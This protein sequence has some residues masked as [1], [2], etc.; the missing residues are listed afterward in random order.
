MTAPAQ[1]LELIEIPITEIAR[2]NHSLILADI[3]FLATLK[4]VEAT[5]ASLTITDAQS[6]QCAADLLTRLTSAGSALEKQRVALKA[7][8]LTLMKAIDEAAK[9]PAFRIEAAK[10]TLSTAQTNFAIAQRKLAE[11]AERAR[12]AELDR[13]E[14]LR[15]AEEK[16]AREKAARIAEDLRLKQEADAKAAEAA[17][18]AGLPPPPP[19]IVEEV[20]DEE[21]PEAP[22]KTET[23]KQIEAVRYAP[24]PVV[25]KA[26]GVREI[27]VLYP[28]CEDINK[29]P[30]AFVKKEFKLAAV[31]ATFCRGWKDGDTL[32]VLDGVRF[33]IQRS[34]V[35]TGKSGF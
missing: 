11:E 20:W 15:L 33:E 22:Q 26:S 23:E 5:V 30:D 21:V 29:V 3:K 31:Q 27:V 6:A 17:R 4:T 16:A 32:P 7:P 14:R 1:T 8:Y 24:A 12:Q 28:H 9:A 18:V 19:P 2:P 35:S 34:T 25:V 10:R 13:L